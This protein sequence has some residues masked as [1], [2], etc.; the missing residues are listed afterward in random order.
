[1]KTLEN[2]KTNILSFVK[3]NLMEDVS[4]SI[5]IDKTVGEFSYVFDNLY[6]L[7]E[8]RAGLNFVSFSIDLSL[9][10]IPGGEYKLTLSDENNN[11][12]GT[13]ICNVSDYTF[14]ESESTNDIFGTTIKISNL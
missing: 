11:D 1:M 10:D 4:Y 3:M 7:N 2:N 9:I 8:F 6:E 14:V 13:Y 12:Y 5:T